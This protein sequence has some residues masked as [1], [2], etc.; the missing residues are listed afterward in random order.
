MAKK[1]RER[2]VDPWGLTDIKSYENLIQEFGIKPIEELL[3]N[4]PNPSKY[5]RRKIVFGHTDLE[6]I[7]EALKNREPYAVMSG[8][9]PSGPF[10]VGSKMTAEEIIYFQQLSPK[11]FASYCIA[12]YEAYADNRQSLEE[13]F[14]I[15][16]SHLADILSLG[17][18]PKRA[19]IYRQ[20]ADKRVL[21]MAF[22]FSRDVTY[23]MLEAIYGEKPF[24]LYLSALIQVGDI[25]LPQTPDF[26]GPKPVVVPV[27]ADQ[28][29]HIRLTR[30]IARKNQAEKGYILPSATYHKLIRS[31][32]GSGKMSKREPMGLLSLTDD[33]EFAEKKIL[34][35]YTGGRESVRAQR[36]LGGEPE[37]CVVYEYLMFH[38]LEDDGKLSTI[39]NECVAGRRICGPCKAEAAEI[40]ANYLRRHQEKREKNLPLAREILTRS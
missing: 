11:A 26:D 34:Q 18:D 35:A 12:D 25:L 1:D 6:R 16:V 36:E 23:N 38:F 30:D 27:G 21:D 15:A 24:G 39:Y 40:V 4:I 5:L 29:P 32:T 17:L 3:G 9:K 20:S 31:L 14:D 28:A 37:K 22:A 10:H 13:S 8:I 2:S 19:Y 33:P 7:L